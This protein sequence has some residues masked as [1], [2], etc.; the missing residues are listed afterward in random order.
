MYFTGKKSDMQLNNM[1][2]WFICFIV[3]KRI[4]LVVR[5][6]NLYGSL[7]AKRASGNDIEG[8]M[9]GDRND[10]LFL[11]RIINFDHLHDGLILQAPHP[12]FSVLRPAHNPLPASDG[13][14]RKTT[15]LLQLVT[16]VHL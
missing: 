9:T 8:W 3:R 11:R 15:I 14:R 5:E 4:Y 1:I 12:N 13:K 10:D 16:G 6:P 2:F 7:S